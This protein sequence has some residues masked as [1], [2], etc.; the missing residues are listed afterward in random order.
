MQGGNPAAQRHLTQTGVSG[1]VP[2]DLGGC[3]VDEDGALEALIDA[4]IGHQNARGICRCRGWPYLRDW[5]VW[6]LVLCGL[7]LLLQAHGVLDR[8]NGHD[9]AVHHLLQG[10]CHGIKTAGQG[11][12]EDEGA[13]EHAAIKVNALNEGSQS[14]P[15]HM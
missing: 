11:R 4:V 6:V 7:D 10:R 13:D 15:T 3:G 8:R 9:V 5:H 14:R 12:D 1:V 2:Y